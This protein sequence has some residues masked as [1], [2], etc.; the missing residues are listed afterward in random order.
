MLPSYCVSTE[1]TSRIKEVREVPVRSKTVSS[2]F[3]LILSLIMAQC[4][5]HQKN[6]HW[7]Y[8]ITV[9]VEGC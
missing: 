5:G 1:K 7:Q 9:S 3:S 8:S 2:L 4:R 6:C